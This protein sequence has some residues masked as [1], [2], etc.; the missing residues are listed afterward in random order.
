MPPPRS[1]KNFAICSCGIESLSV[2]SSSTGIGSFAI[3]SDQ[4]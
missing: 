1:L 3:S 2:K 4:S